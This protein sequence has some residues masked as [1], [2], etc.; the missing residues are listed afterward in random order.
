MDVTAGTFVNA[1]KCEVR[2]EPLA[3]FLIPG[4]PKHER[5]LGHVGLG[6]IAVG[7]FLRRALIYV[8]L[9]GDTD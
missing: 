6:V 2:L 5:T 8:L 3:V 9:G 1:K 7:A 4:D